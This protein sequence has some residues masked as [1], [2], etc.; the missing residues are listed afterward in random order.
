MHIGKKVEAVFK[1][2][3]P[4]LSITAFAGEIGRSRKNVY[5]LFKQ[6]TIDTG[7]LRKISKV[8]NHDFFQYM[9]G[10]EEP[11]VVADPQARYGKPKVQPAPAGDAQPV[12]LV[13]NLDPADPNL[14]RKITEIMRIVKE[15]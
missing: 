7:L 6:P 8:L 3:K 13:L 5:E 12:Q 11:Q 1:G 9:T 14:T 15:G 4:R 2:G 10:V